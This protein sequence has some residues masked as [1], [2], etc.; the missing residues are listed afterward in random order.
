MTIM[1]LKNIKYFWVK[2]WKTETRHYIRSCYTMDALAIF[3]KNTMQHVVPIGCAKFA[4]ED[5]PQ[6][7][8]V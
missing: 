4:V 6:Y 1:I 5:I 7:Y 8:M 3:P 2:P